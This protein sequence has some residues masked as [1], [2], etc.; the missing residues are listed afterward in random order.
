MISDLKNV[1]YAALFEMLKIEM[2]KIAL[3]TIHTSMRSE[4]SKLKPGRIRQ[5]NSVKIC[6]PSIDLRI[7]DLRNVKY[8]ALFEMLKIEKLKINLLKK[9]TSMRSESSKLQDG[10]IRQQKSVILCIPSIDSRISDLRT[11]KDY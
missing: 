6:I 9:H 4:S 3:L 8:A 11:V 2:L 5:Q 7:S 1:K 10:R